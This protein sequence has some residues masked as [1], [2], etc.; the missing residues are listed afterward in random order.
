ML[1]TNWKTAKSWKGGGELG[2]TIGGPSFLALSRINEVCVREQE[3][4]DKSGEK[5]KGSKK[6][7]R[8]L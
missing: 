7:K 2:E 6:K 3:K 5:Y 4:S 8:S 1:Q